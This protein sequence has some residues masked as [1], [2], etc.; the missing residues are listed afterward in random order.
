MSNIQPSATALLR[1]HEF[2][3]WERIMWAVLW[4]TQPDNAPR[5]RHL[6]MAVEADGN[7]RDHPALFNTKR[8]AQQHINRYFDWCR[9]NK[10]RRPPSNNRLPR[11]YR[12]RVR[13]TVPLEDTQRATA[14]EAM[15]RE[16]GG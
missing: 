1:A 4:D 10:N 9:W 11:P 15:A 7:Y 6:C 8:E 16:G 13:I 14:R 2:C 3:E 5:R 12:V